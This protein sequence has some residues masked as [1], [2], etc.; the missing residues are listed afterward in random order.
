MSRTIHNTFARETLKHPKPNREEESVVKKTANE[1]FNRL[2]R[3]TNRHTRKAEKGQPERTGKELRHV[4]QVVDDLVSTKTTLARPVFSKT[5][6]QVLATKLLGNAGHL[7]CMLYGGSRSGKTFITIRAIFM[8]AL[9][10]PGSRHLILRL[11]FSHAKQSIWHDTIPKVLELCFPDLKGEAHIK[12]N[13]QDWFIELS[14]GS[15][16][17]LGGLDDKE[18]VEKILGTEYCTIY[19]NECSQLAWTSVKMAITRLAQVVIGC[20][21]KLY[22]DCNP[23]NKR[24]WTYQLWIKKVDPVSGQKLGK[25]DKYASMQMNPMDNVVNLGEEYVEDILD[26]LSEREKQRFR[27]GMFLDDAEGALFKYSDISK[28]RIPV[29]KF[30]KSVLDFVVIAIDP[31]VTNNETSDE[32]GLIAVGYN[33]NTKDLYILGDGSMQGSP[34]E[35]ALQA[36]S[37]YGEHDG[38]MVIGEVNNGGDLV[39]VNLRTVTKILPFKCVRASKGKAVRAEPVASMCSRGKLH[40]VGEFPL[41]EEELTSWVPDVGMKSPNRFDAMVWGCSYFIKGKKKAGSW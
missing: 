11:H 8:R 19:F 39:E 10:Y 29:E 33:M 21:R 22:F 30:D 12:F 37:M 14:N 18:R 7:Y 28:H 31:A 24:H 40:M 20:R 9:K 35:W 1:H 36:V 6:K 23:P 32:H 25:P 4:N 16:I 2:N 15:Q 41:L 34:R 17:W 38:D 3:Q 26:S 13:K 5:P 27:D